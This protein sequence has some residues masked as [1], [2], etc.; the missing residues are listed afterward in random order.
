MAP[1]RPEFLP[2]R[3]QTTRRRLQ[4]KVTLIGSGNMGSSL[5]K[6]IS[7][8]GHALTISGRDAA[9]AQGLAKASGAGFKAVNAAEGAD[10]VILATAYGDAVAALRAAGDLTL[11]S[12]PH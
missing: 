4:M 1:L 5:A 10:L 11:R 9:K 7:K 8:A 6:Q 3:F 12:H 2:V